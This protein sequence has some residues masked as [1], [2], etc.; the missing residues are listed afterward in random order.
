[1]EEAVRIADMTLTFRSND[2]YSR[3]RYVIDG[4]AKAYAW[5][6]ETDRALDVIEEALS[7]PV[8]LGGGWWIGVS[9]PGFRLNPDW[10]E[11]RGNPRFEAL[12]DRLEAAN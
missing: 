3:P 10:D 4:A 11:L 9:G 12:V 5:A 2:L 7:T 1:M 8:Q 6:G